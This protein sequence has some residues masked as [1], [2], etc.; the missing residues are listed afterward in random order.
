MNYPELEINLRKLEHNA[1]LEV[2]KLA[3]YGVT[4]M[5]VNQDAIRNRHYHTRLMADYTR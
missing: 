2:Q 4:V 1:R 3:K 5:G